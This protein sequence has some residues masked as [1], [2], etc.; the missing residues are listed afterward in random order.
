[1][2][3]LLFNLIHF[4]REP[5]TSNVRI[6]IKELA[7]QMNVWAEVDVIETYFQTPFLKNVRV[8]K[9]YSVEKQRA[10]FRFRYL[11]KINKNTSESK[12]K[13]RHFFFCIQ[14]TFKVA[15]ADL[16]LSSERDYS[17]KGKIGKKASN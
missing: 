4:E 12:K 3:K 7:K 17:I 15:L 14:T 5:N 6:I 2:H 8:K 11:L 1:M 16:Y 9:I 10:L 13:K